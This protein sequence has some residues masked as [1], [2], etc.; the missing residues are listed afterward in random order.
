MIRT[1][2][3]AFLGG[4]LGAVL[5]LHV[6]PSDTHAAGGQ[7]IRSTRFE[8]ID[9]KGNLKA[10]WGVDQNNRVLISFVD[11]K[12]NSRLELAASSEGQ[13]QML[14]FADADG[15]SRVMLTNAP[16]LSMGDETR[17]AQ[18]VLGLQRND[19]P[20]PNDERSWGLVFPKLGSLSSWAALGVAKNP[21]TGQSRAVLS[22]IRPDG[23]MWSPPER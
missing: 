18:L 13:F 7:P 16:T 12:G 22:L 9:G 2:L 19:A 15:R 5:T 4:V 14:R 10:L 23:R 21:Q 1:V 20:S 17:E 8:L 11:S 6:R 3:A